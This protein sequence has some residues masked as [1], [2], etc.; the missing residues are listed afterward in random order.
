A[1]APPAPRAASPGSSR[2]LTP[3]SRRR[4]GAGRRHCF[5]DPAPG[6]DARRETDRGGRERHYLLHLG[7]R[8]TRVS[9]L[10]HGRAGRALA[11]R[12][13]GDRELDEPLRALVE[14]TFRGLVVGELPG[15]PQTGVA[16]H[17]ILIG[18]GRAASLHGAMLRRS[19]R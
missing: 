12:A 17:E 5:P 19:A 1:C 18:G 3:S 11:L 4:S 2:S 16:A 14:G 9:R 13:Y 6:G 10:P 7:D 15:T 8:H